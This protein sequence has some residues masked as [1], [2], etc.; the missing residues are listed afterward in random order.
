MRSSVHT[1]PVKKRKSLREEQSSAEQ[2]GRHEA[3]P[4]ENTDSAAE[5][6]AEGAADLSEKLASLEDKAPSEASSID[7]NAFTDSDQGGLSGSDTSWE[8]QGWVTQAS[9]PSWL[10]ADAGAQSTGL[11]VTDA[12]V[13]GALSAKTSVVTSSWSMGMPA[14]LGAG[15]L[16]GAGSSHAS[17]TVNPPVV[18]PLVTAI[19]GTA[20]TDTITLRFDKALDANRLPAYSQFTITQGGNTFGINGMSLSNDGLT[21]SLNVNGNLTANLFSLRYTDASAGND[22]NTLQS[23]HDVDVAS[24]QQGLVADGPISGAKIY[25]D[26]NRN[27]IAESSEFTGATTDRF[28]RY[29][30]TSGEQAGPII[31]TG[32]FNVDTGVSNTMVLKAPEGSMVLNPLTTLVQS[33]AMQNSIS[34]QQASTQLANALG[35]GGLDLTYYDPLGAGTSGLAAQKAAAQVTHL[36]QALASD[37]ASSSTVLGHLAQT[38][39]SLPTDNN[40]NLPLLAQVHLIQALLDQTGLSSA[41][42]SALLDELQDTIIEIDSAP[43]VAA[44][45]TVQAS[46]GVDTT[47]PNAPTI[48]MVLP[49]S[50]GNMPEVLV[51]FGT[52]NSAG[53]A[54]LAGDVLK[55]TLDGQIYT[56]TLSS[57]DITQGWAAVTVNMS[58]NLNQVSATLTDRA[59]NTSAVGMAASTGGNTVEIGAQLALPIQGMFQT[60]ANQEL[61]L[62]G[63]MADFS[64]SLWQVI[65]GYLAEFPTAQFKTTARANTP[66][67]GLDFDVL[68][69]EDIPPTPVIDDTPLPAPSPI[70]EGARNDMPSTPRVLLG[71][72]GGQQFEI[73]DLTVDALVDQLKKAYSQNIATGDFQFNMTVPVRFFQ[74]DMLGHVGVDGAQARIDASFDSYV[75]VEINLQGKWDA[76][77]YMVLDTAKTKL[78]VTLDGG[79]KEGSQF[80]LELGPLVVAA[81]DMDSARVKATAERQNTGIYAVMAAYIKDNDDKSDGQLTYNVDTISK[82]FNQLKDGSFKI[83]DWYDFVVNA[84]GQLSAQMLGRTD[85]QWLLPEPTQL[86]T[87]IGESNSSFLQNSADFIDQASSQIYSLLTMLTPQVSANILVPASFSYDSRLK[88][89]QVSSEYGKVYFDDIRIGAQTL[90]SSYMEPGLTLLNKVMDPMYQIEDFLNAPLDWPEASGLASN[91]KSNNNWYDGLA[92][93]LLSAT[94][95]ITN[96]TLNALLASLDRNSDG[97]V[98]TFEAMRST[99]D[100][101]HRAALEIASFWNALQGVPGIKLTLESAGKAV[102]AATGVDVI[103]GLSNLAKTVTDSVTRP[104]ATADNPN[105]RSPIEKV[106]DVLDTVDQIFAIV[107]Q[108]QGLQTLYDQ[109]KVDMQRLSASGDSALTFSLGSYVWDIGNSAFTQTRNAYEKKS[110]DY[111]LPSSAADVR[112]LTQEEAIEIIYNQVKAGTASSKTISA[113][114]FAQAGVDFSKLDAY[115]SLGIGSGVDITNINAIASVLNGNKDKVFSKDWTL[116]SLYSD[117]KLLSTTDFTRDLTEILHYNRIWNMATGKGDFKDWNATTISDTLY[118]IGVITP[119]ERELVQYFLSIGEGGFISYKDYL[120]GGEAANYLLYEIFK[121]QTAQSIDTFDELSLLW[122]TEVKIEKLTGNYTAAEGVRGFNG[123][124]SDSTLKEH[125]LSFD[126]FARIGLPIYSQDRAVLKEANEEL[127]D[128][129]NRW[130]WETPSKFK[131]MYTETADIINA[132]N[133]RWLK[134]NGVAGSGL[135]QSIVDKFM[136]AAQ[137][138]AAGKASANLITNTDIQTLQLGLLEDAELNLLR[139]ALTS[140]KLNASKVNSVSQI[141]RLVDAVDTV[142]NTANDQTVDAEKFYKAI[143]LLLGTNK[144]GVYAED[145]DKEYTYAQVLDYLPRANWGGIDQIISSNALPLFQSIIK[146]REAVEVDSYDELKKLADI[147]K[148]IEYTVLKDEKVWSKNGWGNTPTMLND[149]IIS[150]FQKYSPQLTYQDLGL[151]GFKNQTAGTVGAV[152]TRLENFNN[153]DD[154]GWSWRTWAGDDYVS[155]TGWAARVTNLNTLDINALDKLVGESSDSGFFTELLEKSP[156]LAEIYQGLRDAGFDFPFISDSAMIQKIWSGQPLDLVTFTPDI[157]TLDTGNLNI[158]NLDLIEAA[159]LDTYLGGL[160]TAPLQA[161]FSAKLASRLSFGM[162]TGGLIELGDLPEGTNVFSWEVLQSL[163]NGLYVNDKYLVGGQLQDLPELEMDIK[164][165]ALLGVSI[166]AVDSLFNAFAQLSSS[167]DLGIDY[168]LNNDDPSGKARMGDLLLQLFTDPLSIGT[169]DTNLSGTLGVK[170]KAVLDLSPENW[171]ILDDSSSLTG[172]INAFSKA[173]NTIGIPSDITLLNLDKSETHPLIDSDPSTDTPSLTDVLQRLSHAVT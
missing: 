138:N 121:N 77:K 80:A 124:E 88:T 30:L 170:A 27:G 79:L 104:P 21:L 115:K 19:S 120:Y 83:P 93:G 129:P 101:Y 13:S 171:G 133:A 7:S 17:G 28:G 128:W 98:S 9:S 126:D 34:A 12:A 100:N 47:A 169:L 86:K 73:P 54:A 3:A 173:L 82:F 147:T 131:K 46:S 172:L 84:E 53:R 141:T 137:E 161:D 25:I 56:H 109:A 99:V 96:D 91:Y 156:W 143:D 130:T 75:Q 155:Y 106:Q 140:G 71:R 32:G 89:S 29:I 67:A 90:M 22:V 48:K 51:G 122:D 162:D 65:K 20:S 31:A 168:D 38:L 60:L 154:N 92:S 76:Q 6:S 95:S 167:L 153:D 163:L 40:A 112:K 63:S 132:D 113:E 52:D 125:F 149:D 127:R 33:L 5:A 74:E 110:I 111:S 148:D 152:I 144:L 68:N 139:S 105:P 146:R 87:L 2:Q 59:G 14:M 15:L 58:S 85:L 11:V 66:L 78:E 45:S 61:P 159:G 151:L 37:D 116:D 118:Q 123:R 36:V 43:N 62:I 166:G 165:S 16:V 42:Q 55:L 39:V 57:A 94:D 69:N 4:T 160:I 114:L 26:A 145:P 142:I 119:A 134:N 150:A 107:D 35:L 103:A 97:E 44:I 108:L 1:Q 41:Q 64:D 158:F 135:L 117:G 72:N 23:R 50:L 70:E 102:L 10:L 164:L 136:N 81:S 157:P 8:L 24:F 18:R 49:S